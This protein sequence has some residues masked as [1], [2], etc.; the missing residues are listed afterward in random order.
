MCLSI[1]VFEL[2]DIFFVIEEIIWCDFEKFEKEYK[3]SWSYGG[4]VSI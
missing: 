4:V 3:L 2:S 1:C